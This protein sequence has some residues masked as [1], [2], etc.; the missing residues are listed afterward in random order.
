MDILVKNF[1]ESDH[2]LIFNNAPT[3]LKRADD[4]L[5]ACNMPKGIKHWG[6]EK[7]ITTPDGKMTKEKVPMEDGYFADGH[8]QP[9]YFPPGHEHVGKFKGMAH[10]LKER[11]FHDAGKLKAQC[12][13]FKCP[14]GVT[15][16]CCRLILFNQPDFMNVPTLLE[17]HCQKRG[18]QVIILP[19]FHCELSF[20]EQCWGYAKWLYRLYPPTKKENEME[21]NMHKALDTVPIECMRQ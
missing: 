2:V 4:S 6:V 10:I 5:S 12:K 17:T 1:P 9:F 15:D 16:C 14:E 19:K 8:P 18:F 3:H 21:A 20:I 7:L 11:G 13:G